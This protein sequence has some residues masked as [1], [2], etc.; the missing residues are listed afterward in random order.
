MCIPDGEDAVDSLVCLNI[1][2]NSSHI[3]FVWNSCVVGFVICRWYNSSRSLLLIGI[4][5]GRVFPFN[6]SDVYC[7]LPCFPKGVLN[8]ITDR[9]LFLGDL[10]ISLLLLNNILC[11][12]LQLFTCF[13]LFACVWHI[14]WKSCVLGGE[15]FFLM[16]SNAHFL[17]SPFLL[18]EVRLNYYAVP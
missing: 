6:T 9:H 1:C 14:M 7:L 12:S 5:S 8:V 16:L 18:F 10:I 17:H 13:Q 11:T 4:F 3:S 2:M 15:G